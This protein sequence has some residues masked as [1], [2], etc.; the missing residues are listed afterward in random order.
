MR[1]LNETVYGEIPSAM[2]IAE[3]STS[4]P[5]VSKP[6]SMGGLGFGYK[7]NMGW[8]NDTLRYMARDPAHRGYH[9]NELTFGMIYAYSENFILPLA[10][11][12]VVH[13]K[14][15]LYGKMPGDNWQKFA[16]LRLALSFMYAYPGKKLLFMGSEFG[17][18]LE[19]NH[20]CELDWSALANDFNSGARLM[21]GDLNRLHRGIGALHQLDCEPGGFRWIDCDDASQNVIS[22]IRRGLGNDFV[23]VV[24]NFSPVVR[25]GY[26]VGVPAPGWYRECFNSDAREYSGS[27]V[28]SNGGVH[29]DPMSSHGFDQ[30][31]A[32]TLPPLATSIFLSP[33]SPGIGP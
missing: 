27:G 4:W 18:A 1:R 14:G 8:M 5:N 33:G 32:L 22:F 2:T 17:Q 20:D 9:H 16:N 30:T 28:G 26:R 11:D 10:H 13:G 21:V 19:W 3:E 25:Y 7:W 24:C 23:V 29:S 12:E 31:I 15:S 6:T